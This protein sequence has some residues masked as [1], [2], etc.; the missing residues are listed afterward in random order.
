MEFE[1]FQQIHPPDG[2][3]A[4]SL[5]RAR[6][7]QMFKRAPTIGKPRRPSGA[8]GTDIGLP[9]Q[10]QATS[11]PAETGQHH[12]STPSIDTTNTGN[13]FSST[14]TTLTPSS[15][16]STP[17]VSFPSSTTFPTSSPFDS[18]ANSTVLPNEGPYAHLVTP[19]LPFAP[20]F[21]CVFAT[22]CDVLIDAY[23]RLL[24]IVN[25]PAV[26]TVSVGDQFNKADARIRKVMVGGIVREFETAAREGAKR[27]L[28]G[29]Q[30]LVLGGLTGA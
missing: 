14:A 22:L 26:C 12:A 2:S 1:A 24:Q 23:Q 7:P 17:A 20:D 21:Y 19:P 18:H 5:S 10:Q 3:S 15:A 13:T 8:A 30:R 11:P 25:A 9:M 28:L 27:E 6:I 29:V 4:S 16:T